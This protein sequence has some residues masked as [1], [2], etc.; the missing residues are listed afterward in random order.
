MEDTNTIIIF[1]SCIVAIVIF[2]KVLI[3]PLKNIIKLVINSILGGILITI[4]NF[5]RSNI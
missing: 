2:G 1:L 3:W 4:I 5:V